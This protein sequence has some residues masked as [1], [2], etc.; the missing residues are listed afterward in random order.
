MDSGWFGPQAIAALDLINLSVMFISIGIKLICR[1]T[2]LC[3]RPVILYGAHYI[4]LLSNDNTL[5][6]QITFAYV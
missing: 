4:K 2:Y 1:N 6:I 3:I 5:K